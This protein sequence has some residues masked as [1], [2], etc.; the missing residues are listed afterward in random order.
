MA[1]PAV[2][3]QLAA[4]LRELDE[5][6]DV[7]KQMFL[8]GLP[9]AF[10]PGV[11]RY[12]KDFASLLR[13]GLE[14]ASTVV[15]EAQAA[16]AQVIND[17]Q[18]VQET[19]QAAVLST[20]AAEVDARTCFEQMAAAFE[21]TQA[22]VRS[23]EAL[24]EEAEVAKALMLAERQKLEVAKGEVESIRNGPLRVLVDG[25][26][27]DAEVRDACIEA[28]CGYLETQGTDA[29]LLAAL[30]KALARRPAECGQFDKIAVDEAVQ[31]FSEKEANFAA[32]FSACEAKLEELTAT[33]LGAW[34]IL[35]LAREK[36][37]A[38]K[39]RRDSANAA[40]QGASQESKHAAA[41]VVEQ[42]AT[43]ATLQSEATS[44]QARAQQ[45]DVALGALAQLESTEPSDQGSEERVSE[46]VPMG[47]SE[48]AVAVT[49]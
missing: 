17:A 7:V 43:L 18:A 12:Q 32:Q 11:H 45:I 44:L 6:P 36:D 46:D 25:G 2:Q 41:K 14:K 19:Y 24:C 20:N 47:V 42:N 28:V 37:T 4:T 13:S 30:R 5:L 27:G 21:Q 8:A 31:L 40:L 1:S 48:F 10:G 22:G 15:A 16:N 49:A 3:S 23:E 33:H 39:E 35:D 34:A 38:A 29:V 9:N 26:W